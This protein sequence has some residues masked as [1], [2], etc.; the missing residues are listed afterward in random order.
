MAGHDTIGNSY[1]EVLRIAPSSRISPLFNERQKRKEADRFLFRQSDA[2]RWNHHSGRSSRP[3]NLPVRRPAQDRSESIP[4]DGDDS[5]KQLPRPL[6][7][8]GLPTERQ[9]VRSDQHDAVF[10]QTDQKRM[11]SLSADM[12]N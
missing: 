5:A 3:S 11:S 2:T 12:E 1:R 8:V 9:R 4:S 10:D 7:S 6:Q